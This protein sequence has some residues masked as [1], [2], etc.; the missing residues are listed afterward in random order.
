[1]NL[2]QDNPMATHINELGFFFFLRIAVEVSS[3]YNIISPVLIAKLSRA[4]LT[5][6]CSAPEASLVSCV[7][8]L[9][10]QKKRLKMYILKMDP[11]L[12]MGIIRLGRHRE[13]SCRCDVSLLRIELWVKRTGW[14]Q[15]RKEGKRVDGEREIEEGM[16]K[17][18]TD[19]GRH[20]AAR[21]ERKCW[22]FPGT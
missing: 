6:L 4:S 21:D 15:R 11:L 19:Q 2:N 18:I 9:N 13:G 20:L 8:T 1:M 7:S 14:S 17:I 3:S 10:E 22:S 16:M 12:L 5:S